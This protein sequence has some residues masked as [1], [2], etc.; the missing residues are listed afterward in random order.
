MNPDFDDACQRAQR[1]NDNVGA[2]YGLDAQAFFDGDI[3]VFVDS[4]AGP[5]DVITFPGPAQ[6]EDWA[7]TLDRMDPDS[8]RDAIEELRAQTQEQKAARWLR[9]YQAHLAATPEQE[10]AD[11]VYEGREH[12]YTAA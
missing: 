4:D 11:R 7:Q 8:A 9:L 6:L 12:K 1:F 5:Y 3:V 2:D 10:R